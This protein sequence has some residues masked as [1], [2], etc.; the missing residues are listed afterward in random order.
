LG[1]QLDLEIFDIT[2]LVQGNV[3]GGQLLNF[4]LEAKSKFNPCLNN[5]ITPYIYICYSDR[6]EIKH[7]IIRADLDT[8]ISLGGLKVRYSKL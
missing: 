7:I 8:N 5:E 1:D 6:G 3:R 2:V 4:K